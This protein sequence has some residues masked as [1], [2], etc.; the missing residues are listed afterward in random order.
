MRPPSE[1]A[2]D[3][4]DTRRAMRSEPQR[5]T[6]RLWEPRRYRQAAPSPDVTWPEGEVVFCWLALRPQLEVRRFSAP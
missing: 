2:L 6:Y 5:K 4:V 3:P 1:A